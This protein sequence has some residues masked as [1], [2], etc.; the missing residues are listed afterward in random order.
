MWKKRIG[1]AVKGVNQISTLLICRVIAFCQLLCPAI[2]KVLW[3]REAVFSS[4]NEQLY[5]YGVDIRLKFKRGT[6]VM[7]SD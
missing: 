5:C 2:F 7:R 6:M 3:V 4:L 1:L